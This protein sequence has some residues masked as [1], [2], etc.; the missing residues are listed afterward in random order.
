[1]GAA[2]AKGFIQAI[3]DYAKR[4]PKECVGL[5]ISEYDFAAFQ[6]NKQRGIKGVSLFQYDNK[7]DGVVDGWL[8]KLLGSE[9]TE[10]EEAESYNSDSNYNGEHSIFDFINVINSL[11]EGSYIF[12]GTNFIKTK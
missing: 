4:H 8:G 11:P 9:H 5:S 1:M 7:G 12:D 10:E 3:V 6:Q 2:Y